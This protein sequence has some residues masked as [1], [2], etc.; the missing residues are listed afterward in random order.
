MVPPNSLV[1]P[2]SSPGLKSIIITKREHVNGWAS[3][4]ACVK[5]DSASGALN[6]KLFI[7]VRITDG[8]SYTFIDWYYGFLLVFVRTSVHYAEKLPRKKEWTGRWFTNWEQFRR[9][10]C[11]D[12]RGFKYESRVYVH[13]QFSDAWV[14][15]IHT[16]CMPFIQMHVPFFTY[17]VHGFN[18]D[19]NVFSF[20]II[21]L[22]VFGRLLYWMSFW[23]IIEYLW[24]VDK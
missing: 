19:L 15:F 18:G 4:S 12:K 22:N 13:W 1:S 14:T 20:L 8:V 5:R 11:G 24:L 17:T 9:R 3:F 2:I 6:T 21:Y 16:K 23:Q 7:N 10:L